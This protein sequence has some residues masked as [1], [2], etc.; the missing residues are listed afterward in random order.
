M[1]ICYNLQL[2]PLVQRGVCLSIAIMTEGLFTIN[3]KELQDG[4]MQTTP[5]SQ[6]AVPPPL[7]QGRIKFNFGDSA[8]PLYRG[9]LSLILITVR[10]PCTGERIFDFDG[11][12]PLFKRGALIKL[13]LREG[14]SF[15][16]LLRKK[17]DWLSSPVLSCIAS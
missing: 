3:L 9:G 10:R 12:A 17:P 4:G 14:S 1:V 11:S 2:I 5:P 7:A 8:V 15:S 16:I 13:V 6:Q